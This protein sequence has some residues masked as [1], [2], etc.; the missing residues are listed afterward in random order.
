MK[1][2]PF[3]M[4]AC[5]SFGLLFLSACHFKMFIPA[6]N[7]ELYIIKKDGKTGYIDQWG[8]EVIPAIYDTCGRRDTCACSDYFSKNEYGIIKKGKLYGAINA[9]GKVIIE[10][11]YDFLEPGFK[12][13]F[14][15]RAGAK[16]TLIDNR[17]RPVFPFMFDKEYFISFDT[18]TSGQSGNDW[19]LLYP[20]T[21]KMKKTEYQYISPFFGGLAEIELN[22]KRGFIDSSGTLRIPNRFEEVGIFIQG[23]TNVKLNGKWGFIDTAGHFV[24]PPQFE[25]TWGF[26]LSYNEEYAIIT[27]DHKKGLINR[28]GKMIL[29]AVYE[30]LNFENRNVLK[31]CF[32]ESLDNKCGLIFLKKDTSYVPLP[33]HDD[34]EYYEGYITSDD[35]TRRGVCKYK[36]GK[37]VVP[38]VFWRLDYFPSG[39]STFWFLDKGRNKIVK[40]YL[41]KWGRVIWVEDGTNKKDIYPEGRKKYRKHH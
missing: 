6:R 23:L 30:S 19:Y 24:I 21:G 27:V 36:S 18:V 8:K 16:W 17:N 14:R 41:N 3:S 28:N 22:G 34:F 25:D 31:A 38:H 12:N 1:N 20:L 32:D 33:G 11:Q 35:S 2:S 39:L 37:V 4:A 9:K 13:Y 7:Q 40:G 15:A 26:D 29:P 10:P 5:L